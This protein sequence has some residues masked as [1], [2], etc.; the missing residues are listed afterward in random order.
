MPS[1]V[2]PV[3][4]QRYLLLSSPRTASNML[5]KILNLDEQ[6]VRPCFQGGY[7]FLPP[8]I[9]RFG[10][11][12]KPMSE[13]TEEE[14]KSV[15]DAEKDAFEKMQDH[16]EKANEEKQLIYIKEHA[17][18]LNHPIF[19]SESYHGKGT[20]VGSPMPLESRDG[21]PGTRSEHNKTVLSDEFLM[22][23]KPTFLIRHPAMVFPSLLR[24]SQELELNLSKE[25]TSKEMTMYWARTLYDFYSEK[26][27]PGSEWP[28][29][30]DAD[31]V[32]Q[33]PELITK[34]AVM[35]G[36]D[37]DKLRFS[38]EKASREEL[39]KLS[40]REQGMLSSINA[41]NKVDLSK[42]AGNVDIAAEGVKW[43]GEFGE[44]SG[45]KLEELVREAMPDYEFMKSRRL[46]VGGD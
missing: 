40:H 29:V 7:F 31:D 1:A 34:Y 45:R 3:E 46:R 27:G 9:K 19:E 11:H 35:V 28:V 10:L 22:T 30:L 24:K 14:V 33:K 6:G 39:D 38:W 15:Y 44:E 32:M 4:M 5:V 41:S 25:P 8:T 42:L 2:Q 21:V 36:L 13:W 23:W 26:F 43:R 16:V 18:I 37:P 20:T 17:L 12:T